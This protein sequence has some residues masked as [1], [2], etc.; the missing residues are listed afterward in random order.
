MSEQKRNRER[1]SF[2]STAVKV[3]GVGALAA[4]LPGNLFARGRHKH[5]E[6]LE[7]S[8][9]VDVQTEDRPLIFNGRT[10]PGATNWQANPGG[11]IFV[12]VLTNLKTKLTPIYI[13]SLGG[14]T[15][16]FATTGGDCVYPL[17]PL[18]NVP[19]AKGFKI[20]LGW[21]SG[22]HVPLTPALANNYCWHIN[23]IA[24]VN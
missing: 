7:N 24:I 22:I 17:D 4:A 5:P 9:S 19:D 3:A 14:R 23:W 12:E 8:D 21:E 2:L 11:A 16:H 6:V 18:T 10:T 15:N 1:R 20:N 13:V